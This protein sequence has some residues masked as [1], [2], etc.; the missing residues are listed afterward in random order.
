MIDQGYVKN[1]RKIKK[2][3]WYTIPEMAHLYQHLIREANHKPLKWRG[4][5]VER[6]QLI[7]GRN[8]LSQETGLTIKQVRTCL[9]RLEETGEI[10][11][12][13]ANQYSIVTICNY[14]DYQSQEEKEGQPE[15]QPGASQGPAK[16]QQRASNKNDKN[17]KNEK[18]KSKKPTKSKIDLI[19]PFDTPEFFAA[20]NLWK[21]Y[22][23]QQ[24]RFT[25]KGNISEQAA[26]KKLATLAAGDVR[27]AIFLIQN[28][29][30]NNWQ[31]IYE[32]KQSSQSSGDLTDYKQELAER[33][34]KIMND[35]Q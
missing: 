25:F 3:E 28:A 31:G 1:Y 12:E 7:T 6:G 20:W 18:N 11:R 15:G 33:M 9:K 10:I 8:V 16:G 30:Q 35:E 23:R 34:K 29:I 4:K 22:K 26:L 24:F 13:R 5:T 19:Y 21:E 32:A 14:D 17:D 27:Q 2:W